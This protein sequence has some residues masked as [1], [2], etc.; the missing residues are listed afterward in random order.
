MNN[1]QNEPKKVL[2]TTRKLLN[3]CPQHADKFAPS[4]IG[5][6]TGRQSC[7]ICKERH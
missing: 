6:I 7:D 5:E 1:S 4:E 2:K 3:L